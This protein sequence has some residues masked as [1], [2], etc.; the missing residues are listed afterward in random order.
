MTNS[1]RQ[2]RAEWQQFIKKQETENKIFLSKND[3]AKV[4]SNFFG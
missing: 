4:M 3:I 1:E 2:I